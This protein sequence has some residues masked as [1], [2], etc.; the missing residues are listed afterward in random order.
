MQD[1]FGNINT[2]DVLLSDM[3]ELRIN[4]KNLSREQIIEEL[5]LIHERLIPEVYKMMMLGLGTSPKEFFEILESSEI[6]V[7]NANS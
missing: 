4:S 5:V 3:I 1:M 2:V 6:E 7:N